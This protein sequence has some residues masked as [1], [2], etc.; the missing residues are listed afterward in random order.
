[1]YISRDTVLFNILWSFV[2][3]SLTVVSCTASVSHV[4]WTLK[5][6]IV[7]KHFGQLSATKDLSDPGV[8]LALPQKLNHKD[9]N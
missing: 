2:C 9:E 4:A 1:M 6:E 7:E 3:I 5:D 8:F